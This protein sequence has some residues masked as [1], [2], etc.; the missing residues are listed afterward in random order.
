MSQKGWSEKNLRG[1]ALCILL[2]LQ[3]LVASW[4]S[5]SPSLELPEDVIFFQGEGGSL[6]RTSSSIKVV[7]SSTATLNSLMYAA[8]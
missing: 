4:A 8:S 2:Q 3:A 5:S 1:W 6:T 7:N